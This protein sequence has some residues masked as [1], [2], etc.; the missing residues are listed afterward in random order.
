MLLASAIVMLLAPM[1]VQ[2]SKKFLAD[3]PFH[4]VFQ[5]ELM[6]LCGGQASMEQVA[7]VR[8]TLEPMWKTLPKLSS[9]H[10]DRH[11]FRYL[12]YRYF[13]QTSKLMIKGF[14]PNRLVNDTHWGVA[15]ILSKLAPGLV[16][17]VLE[18]DRVK[19]HGFTLIETVNMIVLMEQLI[20]DSE[21]FLLRRSYKQSGFSSQDTLSHIDVTNTLENYMIEWIVE[22]DEEDMEILFA[23]K[24]LVAE[25]LPHYD[26]L[27]KF[28]EGRAREFHF[29]RLQQIPRG[30]NRA[31][32]T[33][34]M[35]YTFEDASAIVGGITQTFASYWQSECEHMKDNMAAMDPHH[36]GRVPLSQLY[37]HAIDEDWRF[38]E[39]EAY[40]RE[41]GALDES[42]SQLGTQVIIPN[43]I[44]STSNCIVSTPYY[45][46]CCQNDCELILAE[47]E[48]R[49][50]TP[51][52]SVKDIL[53]IAGNMSVHTSIDHEHSPTLPGKLTEL[54][55]F[56]AAASDEG[57]VPLHGR[58]FAQWLHYAFPRDCPYP[59]KSG[60][61]STMSPTEFGED[62]IASE[63]DMQK[64]AVNNSDVETLKTVDKEDLDWMSQW[65][66]DEELIVD[67]SP[68]RSVYWQRWLLGAVGVVFLGSGLRTGAVRLSTKSVAGF[69]EEK[70]MV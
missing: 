16:T 15:D 10:I 24:S 6:P 17:L 26:D 40:L 34:N 70:F 2:G 65:D 46:I 22:G 50:Q 63:E 8:R 59:H 12:A 49:L 47:I 57:V 61:V 38:G 13:M 62:Y 29:A 19:S 43:Y 39:S 5:D 1:G 48:D 33:W 60:L 3:L 53:D 7:E 23:N 68:E 66:S 51:T 28:T 9:D 21:N 11:S 52:A 64:Y 31:S 54:L 69:H 45:N 25:V 32:N 41:L 14:E 58:L 67:Y 36:T 20:L 4:G 30:H 18:S 37:N 55:E 44:Q 35:K 56:T 42:S 27:M